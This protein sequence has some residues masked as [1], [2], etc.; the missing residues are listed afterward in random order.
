MLIAI[1]TVELLTRTG[2]LWHLKNLG[3]FLVVITL[4]YKDE[5]TWY[6]NYTGI[7]TNVWIDWMDMRIILR[8]QNIN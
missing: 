8:Y 2:I 3:L 5:L 4:L 7:Y 1:L 6:G